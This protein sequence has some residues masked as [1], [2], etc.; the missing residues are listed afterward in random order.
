[1]HTVMERANVESLSELR[2]GKNFL[3][4]HMPSRYDTFFAR[5][6]EWAAFSGKSSTEAKYDNIPSVSS[7]P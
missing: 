5:A 3:Y 6:A 1:M 2:I 4:D 7:Q